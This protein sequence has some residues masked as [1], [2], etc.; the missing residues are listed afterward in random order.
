MKTLERTVSLDSSLLR[1]A[2]RKLRRY[3]Y[4]FDDAVSLALCVI[5]SRRGDPF[6]NSEIPGPRL[7]AS[8]R[9]ADAIEE[10]SLPAVSYKCGKDVIADCLS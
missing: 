6:A 5:L 4:S 10:G 2:D 1:R 3:G 9:E 8:F 7:I